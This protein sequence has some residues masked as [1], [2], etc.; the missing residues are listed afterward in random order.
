MPKTAPAAMPEAAGNPHAELDGF[1]FSALRRVRDWREVDVD[2]GLSRPVTFTYDKRS[3]TPALLD[4]INQIEMERAA[5]I[6]SGDM[7]KAFSDEGRMRHST[8]E[9]IAQI[10]DGGP[11]WNLP[12][13][14]LDRSALSVLPFPVLA[15]IWGACNRDAAGP[16]S[17][18]TETSF[19]AS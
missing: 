2:L 9:A 15:E 5:A 4:R 16:N 18:E 13:R 19:D 8:I 12:D 10:T 14:A 1:T 11:G 7:K 3:L 6:A 17:S